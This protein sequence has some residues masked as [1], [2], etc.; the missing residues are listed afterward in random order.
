MSNQ[1][2]VFD[3]DDTLCD[4]SALRDGVARDIEAVQERISTAAPLPRVA[5]AQ[6]ALAAGMEVIIMTARC[7]R[8]A[9]RAQVSSFGLDGVR[10][11]F[12]ADGDNR[13]DWKV[14]ADHV[15]ALIAEGVEIIAAF[16]DKESNIKMFQSFGINAV[17]V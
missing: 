16:D 11:A 7:D 15:A 2:I 10:F 14:K 12:R 4:T 8:A 5:D 6:A 13:A 3:L 9:T 17:Q 1:A